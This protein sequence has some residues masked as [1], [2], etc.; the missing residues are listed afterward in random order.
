[1]ARVCGLH[2]SVEPAYA[3]PP[4]HLVATERWSE[5]FVDSR[6]LPEARPCF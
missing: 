5:R 3:L 4:H 2:Q 6:Q 1:M